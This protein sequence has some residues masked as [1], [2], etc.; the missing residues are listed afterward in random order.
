MIRKVF[1]KIH[2]ILSR[3]VLRLRSAFLRIWYFPYLQIGPGCILHKGITLK[4]FDRLS[5]RGEGLK[6][7]LEGNNRIGMYSRIQG[8]AT[9]RFGANSFCSGFNV[10]G[11]NAGV[12]IGKNVMIADYATIRDSDHDFARADCPIKEQGIASEPVTIEGGAWIGHGAII[13]KGVTVGRGAIVAAGAVV[14]KDVPPN[15]IVGGV[16]AKVL[17]YRQGAEACRG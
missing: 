1:K 12:V 10:F 3:A 8:S 4:E 6:V 7:I 16:P 14:T 2:K 13:L 9:I 15:A 11:V 5:K 17:K